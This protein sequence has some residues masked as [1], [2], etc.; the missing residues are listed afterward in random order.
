MG[1]Y[2][3]KRKRVG[4]SD[5]KRRPYIPNLGGGGYGGPRNYFRTH[6]FRYEKESP[7]KLPKTETRYEVIERPST[8]SYRQ[9]TFYRP[10]PDQ[11]LMEKAVGRAMEKYLRN[12]SDQKQESQTETDLVSETPPNLQEV[13]LEANRFVETG[14]ATI[15]Q[16][17]PEIDLT[18][19]L[20]EVSQQAIIDKGPELYD[21]PVADL[22]LLLVE[23]DSNQLEVQPE[24]NIEAE[25]VRE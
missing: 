2:R 23:L 10:E 16:K 12:D 4:R 21:V 22:E 24:R 1:D 3:R 17:E 6:D 5:T 11:A 25:P 7:A 14:P 20:V 18:E 9:P 13:G 15:E 8:E 19:P